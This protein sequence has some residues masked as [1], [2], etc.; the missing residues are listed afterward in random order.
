MWQDILAICS[1][2]LSLA[3][4]ITLLY[5]REKTRAATTYKHGSYSISS[6]FKRITHILIVLG[7]LRVVS[8]STII[9]LQWGKL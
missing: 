5:V 8:A 9:I 2:I 4:I 7:F 3:G 6:W 1:F